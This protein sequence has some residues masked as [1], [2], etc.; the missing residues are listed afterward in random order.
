LELV[1]GVLLAVGILTRPVAL[2]LATVMVGA[3]M[4]A[5]R[6][7]GGMYLLVPPLLFVLCVLLAWRSGRFPGPAPAR[8]PGVQ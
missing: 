1:C 2:L 8:P 6:V 5:G 4:T 7:D 3:M